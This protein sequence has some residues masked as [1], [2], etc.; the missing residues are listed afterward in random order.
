MY[1][2]VREEMEGLEWNGQVSLIRINT[3]FIHKPTNA[4]V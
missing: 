2:M 3:L 1:Q 4:Q